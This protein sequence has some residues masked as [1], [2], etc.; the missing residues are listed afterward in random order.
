MTHLAPI[1]A[2]SEKHLEEALRH[3]AALDP[4]TDGQAILDHIRIVRAYLTSART[5][6]GMLRPTKTAE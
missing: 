2:E 3:A 5:F 4:S 1:F 6:D